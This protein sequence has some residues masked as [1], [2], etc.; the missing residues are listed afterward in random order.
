MDT[1]EIR[2]TISNL[3]KSVDD[4]TILKLLNILNDGVEPTEKLLRDTKVG[5]AV[6]KYRS[7][8]N[9]DVSNLVKKMIKKWRD[10]VQNEKMMKKKSNNSTTTTNND[11]N[12]T[13]NSNSNSNNN[14]CSSS[15]NEVLMRY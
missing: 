13:S 7:H 8:S 4:A 6:N 10:I 2:T 11:T 14:S 5:I 15:A 3:E 1:K 12:N 9:S